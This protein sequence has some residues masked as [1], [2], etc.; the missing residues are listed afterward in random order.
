MSVRLSP[1][2]EVK[3]FCCQYFKE[4]E[5]SIGTILGR[6]ES[7]F[8][9]QPDLESAVRK[10]GAE[11]ISSFQRAVLRDLFSPSTLGVAPGPSGVRRLYI[12]EFTR[13][14]D[15]Q[16]GQIL[17]WL[18]AFADH[19]VT[20]VVLIGRGLLSFD[21]HSTPGYGASSPEIMELQ[22]S[23]S[24]PEQFNA[25][26]IKAR[27]QRQ[28]KGGAP[29]IPPPQSKFS[30]VNVKLIQD[31]FTRLANAGVMGPRQWSQCLMASGCT[32][33]EYVCERLFEMVRTHNRP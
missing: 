32:H 24:K 17:R 12:S 8:G 28:P 4:S 18:G 20:T 5:D 33:N 1:E 29:R 15:M 19:L 16:G 25:L 23:L 13:W 27:A 26:L 2:S 3:L 22:R 9:K 31:L 6:F 11:L 10:T 30:R 7:L 21:E 14:S